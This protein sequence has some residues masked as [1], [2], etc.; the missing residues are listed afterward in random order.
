[1]SGSIRQVIERT[2]KYI[3]DFIESDKYVE[4]A[5]S[6]NRYRQCQSAAGEST[7]IQIRHAR[8]SDSLFRRGKEA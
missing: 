3:I 6:Q 1:M 8:A 4:L 7:L 2:V 5:I